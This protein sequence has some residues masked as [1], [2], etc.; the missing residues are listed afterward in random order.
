MDTRIILQTERLRLRRFTTADAPFIVTLLNSEGW[1]R[2]IG[3]RGVRTEDDAVRYLEAGPLSSYSARGFGLSLVETRAGTPVGMC[4]IL[5]RDTLDH[6]DIGFAFLPEWSGLGY[7]YEI[8]SATMHHARGAWGLT[9][10]DAI[11]LP[12]NALSIR[13]L[14]RLGMQRIGSTAPAGEELYHY[15]STV[16]NA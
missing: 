5:V 16:P 8:A 12:G 6:P 9:T 13:L 15:R 1:L 7:G 14:E 10:I 11:T 4:G 2:Y 3:D